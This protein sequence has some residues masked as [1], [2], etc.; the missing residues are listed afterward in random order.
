ME[1]ESGWQRGLAD[2]G[3]AATDTP[4]DTQGAP[5]SAEVE[6]RSPLQVGISAD[7]ARGVVEV[8]I[9]GNAVTRQVARGHLSIAGYNEAQ[10]SEARMPKRGSLPTFQWTA[11]SE[12]RS[13]PETATLELPF[14]GRSH[15]IAWVDLD[16]DGILSLGDRV[17]SP[18][19]PLVGLREV[20]IELRVDRI[21][22]DPSLQLQSSAAPD[23]SPAASGGR[24][25]GPQGCVSGGGEKF[26]SPVPVR[27]GSPVPVR[28]SLS[29]SLGEI[30]EGRLMIYALAPADVDESGIPRRDSRPVAVWSNPE[31]RVEW[32]FDA[33]VPLPF[34]VAVALIPIWDAD[35]SGR[36][37]TGDCLGRPVEVLEVGKPGPI[38]LQIARRLGSRGPSPELQASG[39]SAAGRPASTNQNS[40]QGVSSAPNT[41]PESPPSTASL[42]LVLGAEAEG[43]SDR[44]L[45]IYGFDLSAMDDQGFPAVGSTPV[46]LE[47]PAPDHRTWPYTVAIHSH[48]VRSGSSAGASLIVFAALDSDSSGF[49]SPGDVVTEA[50]A[51]QNVSAA[52]LTLGRRMEGAPGH[53]SAGVSVGEA[54]QQRAGGRENVSFPT[55][56]RKSIDGCSGN[57]SG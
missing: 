43:L 38:L 5:P 54:G 16:G 52:T 46:F 12:E 7:S 27:F 47:R 23:R 44:P 51:A 29:E 21:F 22:V 55:T 2:V 41:E 8:T 28:V 48:H 17:S 11:G 42:H 35:G 15:L 32:P 31:Q 39:G 25:S 18:H 40:E 3:D 14:D 33:L 50:I 45:L 53:P 13:W 4:G 9:V 36:L 30:G 1:I 19:E 26:G 57:G 6:V 37:S 34:G 49:L 56:S 24:K 10:F 20:G